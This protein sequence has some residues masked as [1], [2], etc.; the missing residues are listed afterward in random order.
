MG[1]Q[2]IEV[3]GFLTV[4]IGFVALV[5]LSIN[6]ILNLLSSNVGTEK[7]SRILRVTDRDY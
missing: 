7:V 4:S 6:M 2:G 5:E 3:A 1:V